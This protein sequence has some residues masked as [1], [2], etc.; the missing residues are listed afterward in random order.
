MFGIMAII[1]LSLFLAF[2]TYIKVDLSFTEF[3]THISFIL[4]IPYLL[5]GEEPHVL[6][7]K[8]SSQVPLVFGYFSLTLAFSLELL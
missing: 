3:Y 6:A 2:A 8:I 7:S 1:I 5:L 4:N